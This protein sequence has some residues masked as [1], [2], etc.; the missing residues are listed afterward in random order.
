MKRRQFIQSLGTCGLLSLV[1]RNMYGM[2]NNKQERPPNIVIILA[3]D[4][5]YGDLSCYGNKQIYTPHLDAMAAGGVRFTDFHSSC[6]VCSPTRAGLLTGR[7]QQR[8]GITEVVTVRRRD[9]GMPLE[10]ITF[11]EVFKQAGYKTGIFGK[12]HLG[13]LPKFNP[14]HQGFDQFHG[15]LSGNVD[16][17]SHIDQA[18]VYDWWHNLEQVEEE[19]YTTHLITQHAVDFIEANHQSPF[20]LYIAHEAPHYPYQGPE[21]KADRT[22]GGDFPNRGS[23]EDADQ[24]YKTMI[25]EMDAGIGKVIQKLRQLDIEQNTFVFF[26]SDNGATKV[27]SNDPLRGYKGSLLEGGHRVPAI[28]YWPGVIPP[29]RTCNQAVICMNIFP[30]ILSAANVSKPQ[31]LKLDGVDLSPFLYQNKPIEKRTLFW[32]FKNQKAVRRG[33]WKL[34]VRQQNEK[35]KIELY[36]LDNDLA[37]TTDISSQHKEIVQSLL[38]ALAEWAR[39]VR[40]K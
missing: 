35:E 33:P 39:D 18:G 25:E 5:G 13:Y 9:K 7:Y 1:H 17:I 40:P 11:A 8:C 38:N 10:E 36:N 15:Y 3:D 30:T 24:A 28:A 32:L 16:Y 14:V 31:N 4:L 2:V 12:W 29:G 20:C 6:S 27:G 34:W 19:G 22:V 37:E 23:R 21:D 26:F